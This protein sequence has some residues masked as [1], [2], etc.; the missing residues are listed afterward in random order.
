MNKYDLR[1]PR[2]RAKKIWCTQSTNNHHYT[3]L[4][5]E[6]VPTQPHQVWCA[7]VSFLKFQGRFWYLAT[8][9]DLVTRQ[10]VAAQ[11]SKQHDQW[12][13]LSA[14]KQALTKFR[15]QI[16]HSDQGTEFMASA[17]TRFLEEQGIK[18]SVSDK[19]S[20]WQNGF[21]ESFF[22]RFKDEF[23]DFNRFDHVGQ[24]IEEIYSQINYYN[25]RRR[26]TAL[27]VAPVV[28]AASFSDNCHQKMGT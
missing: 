6:V 26:H 22:G 7:D 10:V 18:V 19:A 13:I 25:F 5:K 20:P 24:L 8:I 23:G 15:P 17:C 4:I 9:E 16:F 2:R 28:Y 14:L 3:N 12:L 21:Q 1:P 11:V 27:K